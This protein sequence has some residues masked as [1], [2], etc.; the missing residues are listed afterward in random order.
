MSLSILA[1]QEHATRK[2][3]ESKYLTN[4]TFWDATKISES[5]IVLELFTI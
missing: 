4:T 3:K 5:Y 1:E 2:V